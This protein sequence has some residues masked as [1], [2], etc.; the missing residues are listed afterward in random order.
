MERV[1][2]GALLAGLLVGASL[3]GLA[4]APARP[5]R[6]AGSGVSSGP[7]ARVGAAVSLT[8]NAR[9]LGISQRNGIKLAEDEINASGMLGNTHLDVIVR[10]R[11]R[12]RA[13]RGGI[14]ALHRRQSRRCHPWPD[15]L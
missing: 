4:C 9:M 12:S 1:C 2:R 8:G 15:A 6:P 14:P 10:R 3:L 5:A 11:L 13:G 7:V